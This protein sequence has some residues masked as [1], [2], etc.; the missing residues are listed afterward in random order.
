MHEVILS[1]YKSLKNEDL[2]IDL[3]R[4]KPSSSQLDLSNDLLSIDIE[5]HT[6]SGADIRNY[7]EPFGINEA[8]K[9]GAELLEAPI[10]NTIAAEQS[11]L[12]LSYQ[13]LLANYLYGLLDNLE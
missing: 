3:T 6:Q 2:K 7:G 1:Q 11:S 4:G 5:T 13:Y 10:E 8:R 9:L 12:L